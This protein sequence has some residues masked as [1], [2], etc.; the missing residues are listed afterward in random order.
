MNSKPTLYLIPTSLTNRTIKD[1]L[2]Q[3]DIEII[4]TLKHYIV[5]TPKKA[6][7]QLAGLDIILQELDMQV[8]DEHTALRNI[9]FLIE[10][11]LQG[12]NV[13][14][15]SDAGCPAVA[16]P[17]S[18]VVRECHR[19]DIEIKPLVGPSSILLALMGSGLNGQTFTFLGYLPR[20]SQ[21]R[22]NEIR[23]IENDSLRKNQTQIFIEAPY[24]NKHMYND[25]LSTLNP[26]SDLTIAV[27]LTGEKEKIVTKKVADWKKSKE[28]LEDIP[29]IFLILANRR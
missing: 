7:A 8:L 13:G 20:E 14:L 22:I 23:K 27:D 18:L 26:N 2:K 1:T 24:R 6:R 17:G 12:H 15:M 25:L 5:E 9:E 16:D 29:T 11:L 3:S 28:I 10:P 21:N 19:R 4:K